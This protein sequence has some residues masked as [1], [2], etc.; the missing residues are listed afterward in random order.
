MAFA[1]VNQVVVVAAHLDDEVPGSGGTIVCH[2]N[3]L[4]QVQVLVSSEGATSR[5][6]QRDRIQASQDLSAL[7]QAA[8]TAGSFCSV[9]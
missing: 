4:D 5:Q 3:A 9:S 2:A 1:G 6:Q 8:Q 7:A